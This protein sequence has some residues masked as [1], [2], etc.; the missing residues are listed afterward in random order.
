MTEHEA[1]GEVIDVAIWMSGSSSFGKDGEAGE[2]WP[3]QRERLYAAMDVYE[4]EKQSDD[5]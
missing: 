1:L 3:K 5:D 2:H 4:K